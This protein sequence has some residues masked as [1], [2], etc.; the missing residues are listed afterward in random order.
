[1]HDTQACLAAPVQQAAQAPPAYARASAIGIRRQ[2]ALPD[3][4]TSAALAGKRRVSLGGPRHVIHKCSRVSG[5]LWRPSPPVHAGGASLGARRYRHW[6]SPD[7]VCLGAFTSDARRPFEHTGGG[8][9][10]QTGRLADWQR[11]LHNK[12]SLS[13]GCAN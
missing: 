3:P 6:T 10:L 1:M 8:L 7:L 5:H 4:R 13:R 9:V 11:N 12:S 2:S